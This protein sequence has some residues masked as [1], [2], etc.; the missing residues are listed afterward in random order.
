MPLAKISPS[1]RNASAAA[2]THTSASDQS[3]TAAHRLLVLRLGARQPA[4]RPLAPCAR[5]A[6]GSGVLPLERLVPPVVRL[7]GGEVR[8][9]WRLHHAVDRRPLDAQ[10][11]RRPLG[12]EVLGGH[13]PLAREEAPAR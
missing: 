11:G 7:A 9:P 8:A 2:T 6:G 5:V 4:R 12:Q 10:R 13:D 1:P 3:A